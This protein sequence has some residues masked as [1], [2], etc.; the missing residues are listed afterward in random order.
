MNR[1]EI[2]M[3]ENKIKEPVIFIV[4]EPNTKA[5]YINIFKALR[6]IYEKEPSFKIYTKDKTKYVII[7]GVEEETLQIVIEALRK[8]F[9][10][11][12]KAGDTQIIYK[13]TIKNTIKSEGR[14]IKQSG[15]ESYG[16]CFI[17]I[18]PKDRGK[19]YEFINKIYDDEVIPKEFIECINSGIQE[20][21]S[22]GMCCGY[23]LT[24]IK[25]TLYDG[26][27]HKTYS[28]QMAFK[29]AGYIAIREAIKDIELTF[30]EPILKL[31]LESKDNK[32]DI[33]RLIHNSSGKIEDGASNGEITVYIPLRET[34]GSASVALKNLFK[35]ALSIDISHYEEIPYEI[36]K[37]IA[38]EEDFY[39]CEY[40]DLLNYKI[41]EDETL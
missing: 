30:L 29:I 3:S 9:N 17:E 7:A 1:E 8:E 33:I 34:I 20:S 14:Y 15:V 31:V 25:V 41:E 38:N 5:N 12:F 32:E 6:S 18:E 28:R 19:G 40:V 21:I 36:Q 24:D 4:I 37:N 11:E 16:H 22:L 2:V 10:I 23:S 39:R 35:H 13:Q 26:S 27:Y